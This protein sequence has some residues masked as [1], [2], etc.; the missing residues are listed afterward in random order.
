LALTSL[1][2]VCY[3]LTAVRRNNQA[4]EAHGSGDAVASLDGLQAVRGGD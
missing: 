2:R 1:I 3:S 4:F